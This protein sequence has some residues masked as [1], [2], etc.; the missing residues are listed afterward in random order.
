MDT[1]P[2]WLLS[3]SSLLLLPSAPISSRLCG[4]TQEL[5]KA[6]EEGCLPPDSRASGVIE[7]ERPLGEVGGVTEVD[8]NGIPITLAI[9]VR[10]YPLVR[11]AVTYCPFSTATYLQPCDRGWQRWCEMRTFVYEVH[12]S[13]EM[14]LFPSLGSTLYWAH[15]K[16]LHREYERELR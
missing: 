15:T 8:E 7:R 3:P 2:L 1:F 16:L 13:N 12:I 14:V 6:F 10:N 5:L 9:M 11:P 4:S